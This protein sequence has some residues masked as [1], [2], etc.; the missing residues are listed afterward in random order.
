MGSA[1]KA[2]AELRAKVAGGSSTS[3]APTPLRAG[4]MRST[5]QEM[6]ASTN[7]WQGQSE[8]DQVRRQLAQ[9]SGQQR[10]KG[11]RQSLDLSDVEQLI[12]RLESNIFA[13]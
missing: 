12:T 11:A 8:L 2:L 7:D 13:T 6:Q 9:I 3:V 4:A 1:S 10:P 5:R